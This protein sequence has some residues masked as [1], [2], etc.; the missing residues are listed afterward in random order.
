M[1][2]MFAMKTFRMNENEIVGH[3]PREISLAIKFVVDRGANVTHLFSTYYRR[4]P[5]FQ[6]DLEITCTVKI[7]FPVSI[8]AD[9]LKSTKK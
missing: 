1:F 5:L 9:V 4:S 2:S 8:K 3:L 6:G 7:C